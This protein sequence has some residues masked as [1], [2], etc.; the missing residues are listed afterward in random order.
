MI[1]VMAPCLPEELPRPNKGVAADRKHPASK[2][3]SGVGNPRARRVIPL[4]TNVTSDARGAALTFRWVH[5]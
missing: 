2:S 5:A 4:V 1:R 3:P